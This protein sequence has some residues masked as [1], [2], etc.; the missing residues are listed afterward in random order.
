MPLFLGLDFG[1]TRL[2][3][4][5]VDERLRLLLIQLLLR[6]D[7]FRR[8]L[9]VAIERGV[10]E[11]PVRRRLHEAIAA[12]PF[13]WDKVYPGIPSPAVTAVTK[14]IGMRPG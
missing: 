12:R 5:L 8:E 9:L 2:R 6:S 14:R 13:L 11:V 7:A 3:V 10:G 4:G 1:G